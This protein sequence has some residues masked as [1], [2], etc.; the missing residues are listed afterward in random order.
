MVG[1]FRAGVMATEDPIVA[2][3]NGKEILQ[4]EI[5]RAKELLPERY[6]NEPIGLMFPGLLRSGPRSIILSSLNASRMHSVVRQ[7]I[8]VPSLPRTNQLELSWMPTL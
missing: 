1:T 3:V 7:S 4:S 5:V 6:R 2:K 8:S